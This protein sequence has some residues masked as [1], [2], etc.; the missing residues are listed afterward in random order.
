[1]KHIHLTEQ[2]KSITDLDMP[3]PEESL[4]DLICITETALTNMADQM[5]S[6]CVAMEEMKLLLQDLLES[7]DRNMAKG[8]A[9]TD[10]LIAALKGRDDE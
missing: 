3:I 4:R 6:M 5:E 7:T 1:M 9:K 2:S 10:E 8:L